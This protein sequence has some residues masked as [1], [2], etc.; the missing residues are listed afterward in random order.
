MCVHAPEYLDGRY[1]DGRCKP[2]AIAYAKNRYE[3]NSEEINSARRDKRVTN[4]EAFLAEKEYKSANKE[5]ANYLRRIKYADNRQEKVAKAKAWRETNPDKQ[6]EIAKRGRMKNIKANAERAKKW[7][8]ANVDYVREQGAVRM[9][10]WRK[11]NPDKTREK[12]NNPEM[13]ALRSSYRAHNRKATPT[14][15]NAFFIAEIYRLANTRSVSLGIEFQVDHIV[16]LRGKTVCGL[17]VEH[18]LRVIT[19]SDNASKGNRYWPDMPNT[20]E[21]K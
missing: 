14:W 3:K 13:V 18:N 15:A 5:R 1:K 9:Q 4:P 10:E 19:K 7:R 6:K 16:P 8:Q 12:A 20:L 21:E 17:H 11:N 2:C